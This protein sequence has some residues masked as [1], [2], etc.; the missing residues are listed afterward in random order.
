MPKLYDF[1]K[2]KPT[3]PKPEYIIVLDLLMGGYYM[4]SLL[5]TMIS[6]IKP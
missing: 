2:Y 6:F 1:G 5:Q 3:P 4:D